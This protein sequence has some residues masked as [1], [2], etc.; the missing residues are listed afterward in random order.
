MGEGEHNFKID[1][2]RHIWY[3]DD[4][5]ADKLR[6]KKTNKQEWRRCNFLTYGMLNITQVTTTNDYY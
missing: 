4:F 5:G 3:S 2:A 1:G 6:P